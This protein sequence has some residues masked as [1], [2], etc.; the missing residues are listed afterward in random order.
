MYQ[1]EKY[2]DVIAQQNEDTQKRFNIVQKLSRNFTIENTKALELDTLLV[3]QLQ[4]EFSVKNTTQPDTSREIKSIKENTDTGIEEKFNELFNALKN[5]DFTKLS[6]VNPIDIEKTVT[7]VLNKQKIQLSQL[8]ENIQNRLSAQA[9]IIK[10][11][12]P[13]H[14]TEAFKKP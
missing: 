11:D 6:S 5:Q 2:Q 3:Q 14:K 10:Y 9:T 7:A 12:I 13:E 4:L 1:I 8:D